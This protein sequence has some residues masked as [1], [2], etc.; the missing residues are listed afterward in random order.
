M[1]WFTG[2]VVHT[3]VTAIDE[4]LTRQG[5]APLNGESIADKGWL[6]IIKSADRDI[7]ISTTPTTPVYCFGKSLTIDAP[8]RE[9]VLF[10]GV[11]GATVT[12]KQPCEAA[13]GF[14]Y[15]EEQLAG[16]INI[17][18]GVTVKKIYAPKNCVIGNQ[19]QISEGVSADFS[20]LVDLDALTEK[21]GDEFRNTLGKFRA[22]PQDRDPAAPENDN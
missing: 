3:A 11:A 10:A 15:N 18:D 8:I 2:R 13:I 7:V 9:P 21:L 14:Y 19:A 1:W 4:E 12:I 16:V 20:A 17:A 22:A 5:Y 6:E